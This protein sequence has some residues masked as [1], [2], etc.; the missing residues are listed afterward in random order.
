MGRVLTIAQHTVRE[1]LRMKVVLAFAGLIVLLVLAMPF[2]IE[3]GQAT[4]SY[5]VKT[6]LTWSLLPL[7]LLL[8]FLAIFLG[9]QSIS[10]EMYHR[11]IHILATKPIP[12]W[13]YVLGKWVG[14]VQVLTGL[15]LFGG[16]MTYAMA[17]YLAAQP[18][19]DALD[20]EAL[21]KE[22]LVAR[23]HAALYVP[24]FRPQADKLYRQRVDEGVYEAGSAVA[25]RDRSSILAAMEQQ[26]RAV[27]AGSSRTFEFRGLHLVSR[28]A[29]NIMQLSY[30]ARGMGY[31]P[32]ETLQMV[33]DFGSQTDAEMVRVLRRDVMDRYHV[34]SFPATAVSPDGVLQVQLHNQDFVGRAG[35]GATIVFEG[36][37]GLEVLY[38]IGTFEGNLARTLFLIWCRVV[39]IA[40]V[41]VCAAT[42][43][44]YPVACLV[45]FTFYILAVSG[46]YVVDA[47]GFGAPGKG[48]LGKSQYVIEPLVKAVLWLW[49]KFSAYDGVEVF[50]DGRNVTLMWDLQALGKLV[51][52][53]TT[54]FL[55]CA[56]IVFRRRQVAELSV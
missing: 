42:L 53:T 4:V 9:C 49:P 51:L 31:A 28:T 47:L 3:R 30:K 18:P 45:A 6:F 40:A 55:L 8:S 38:V 20:A 13:Q 34:I 43:F 26:F 19:L 27:P 2:A 46:N 29:D 50:A 52:L 56:C 54:L 32:D 39:L 5:T 37:E 16:L 11:Q 14:V 48:V 1:A 35:K 7:G 17:L 10:D 33:W 25:V 23:G 36:D 15:L 24:N 22:V 41:G 12:R 21:E 44:S